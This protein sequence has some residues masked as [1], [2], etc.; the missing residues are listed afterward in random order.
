MK[1][2][3]TVIFDTRDALESPARR[4]A[5]GRDARPAPDPGWHRRAGAGAG[6]ARPRGDQG[7]LPDRQLPRPLRRG[8]DLDRGDAARGPD[9]DRPARAGDGVSPLIITSNDLAAAWAT[10]RRGEPLYPLLP[11][12]ARQRELAFRAGVNIVMYALT[13][14]Y[15]ADQVHVPAL[16]E[17]AR[18]MTGPRLDV[19]DRIPCSRSAGDPAGRAGAA[20]AIPA[21]VLRQRGSIIR[22]LALA[23]LRGARQ[24]VPRARGAGASEGRRRGG[25]GSF[26]LAG[27]LRSPRPDRR[28][29]RRRDQAPRRPSRR[30]N[31][32]RRRARG[33][34]R[35]GRHPPVRA[36]QSGL[37]DVPPDRVAGAILITDGVVHDVPAAAAALGLQ[38]AAAWPRHRPEA[39][40]TGASSSSTRRASASSARTRRSGSG[41]RRSGGAGPR[42]TVR[43][44]GETCR[45]A[46]SAAGERFACRAHRPWRRQ[47]HRVRGRGRSRTSSP[48]I[49]N[50]AVVTIEGIREK[51]RVLLVSGQP[52]AGRAHLAQHPEVGRQCRPRP[53]H[54][55]APAGEAG[56]HADQRA[57]AD[58]LPDARAFRD[59]DQRV[60]PHHL[61]PLRQPV[62]PA[63]STSTTSPAMCATA[64]P[65][66][67]AAGPGI[68]QPRRPHGTP[69]GAVMPADAD[70]RDR[71]GAFPPAGHRRSA[72]AIR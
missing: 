14:N 50:S 6:A 38:G 34:R 37:S 40:A 7:L 29:A 1:S 9:A 45:S 22:A 60:R 53:L 26:R 67:V 25:D 3:G 21:L 64:A 59:E 72:S 30:G 16:L 71:R 51:L 46:A 36:L 31:P 57:L 49:N 32:L 61:R 44:D 47:R 23:S 18:P 27:P 35:R 19:P 11:G 68:R 24:S 54:H 15:K 28:R 5:D 65:L 66:L 10:G 33:R 58:R 13:G 4:A 2:G 62:D 48:P 69:L 8:P 41:R 39:S 52:H 55:P 12:G 20:P 43:R 56:R 70:R 42:V 63:P 17:T